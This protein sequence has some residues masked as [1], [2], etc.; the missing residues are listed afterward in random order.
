MFLIAA[1]TLTVALWYWYRPRRRYNRRRL[2]VSI[3]APNAQDVLNL[4]R[5]VERGD[6]ADM[7]AERMSA[8]MKRFPPTQGT[9]DRLLLMHKQNARNGDVEY[10]IACMYSIAKTSADNRASKSE[11]DDVQTKDSRK[12]ELFSVLSMRGGASIVW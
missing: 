9:L 1:T 5:R 4:V 12:H 11:D 10:A 6:G 2:L 3:D 8:L 7:L